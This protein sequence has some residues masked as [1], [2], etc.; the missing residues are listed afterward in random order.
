MK[1]S[2]II[3]KQRKSLIDCHLEMLKIIGQLDLRNLELEQTLA[4]V[5]K[6]IE[7]QAE[8]MIKKTETLKREL[9]RSM[10]LLN[11]SGNI[12]NSI[13][14]KQIIENVYNAI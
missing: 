11:A 9:A 7:E 13:A 14:A 3:R 12:S 1:K 8:S 5:R 4:K 6:D 10:E 2:K